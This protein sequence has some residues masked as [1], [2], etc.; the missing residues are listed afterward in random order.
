MHMKDIIDKENL[1]IDEYKAV[2]LCEYTRELDLIK[3]LIYV[4]EEGIEKQ[5]VENIWSFKVF[6]ILL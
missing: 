1:F 6:V 3:Q 5:R 2:I 4:A